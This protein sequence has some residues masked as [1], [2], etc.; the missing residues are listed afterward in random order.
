M[1]GHDV[2]ERDKGGLSEYDVTCFESW[3]RNPHEDASLT[4]SVTPCFCYHSLDLNVSSSLLE[5]RV[6]DDTV[7]D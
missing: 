1:S 6:S 3:N 5:F 2:L 7:N 4:L